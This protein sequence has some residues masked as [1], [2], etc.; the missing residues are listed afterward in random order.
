[1]K[2]AIQGHLDRGNEVI[3]V[4]KDLGGINR[5]NHSGRHILQ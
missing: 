1:M 5:M 2:I 3:Q 4:L